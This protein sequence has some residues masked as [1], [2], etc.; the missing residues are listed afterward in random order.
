MR[1]LLL[2]LSASLLVLV[3]ATGVAGA[4]T[5]QTGFAA[6]AQQ[7]GLNSKQ[8]K[9]LQNKADSYLSTLGGKQ[10][11]ADRIKLASGADLVLALPTTGR[12]A[13]DVACKFGH[14]CAWKN[15]NFQGDVIDMYNCA[16]H[17]IP[18]TTTGSWI[19]NQTRG[20]VSIFRD[21]DAVARWQDHGAYDSDYQADWNW[22]HWVQNC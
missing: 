13:A 6:Q 15:I 19:N 8:A 17:V 21:N 1:R 4:S 12:T 22:V 20:T 18:W 16:W 14:M 11:A 5:T 3:T 2:T 9:D 10:V 7:L